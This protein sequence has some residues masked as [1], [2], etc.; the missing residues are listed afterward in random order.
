[1]LTTTTTLLAKNSN[2]R[3]SYIFRRLILIHFFS[4]RTNFEQKF[5]TLRYNC[6]NAKTNFW[7]TDKKENKKN[8]ELTQILSNTQV[9]QFHQS[10]FSVSIHYS[11]HLQALPYHI[12]LVLP[13]EH[14][15]TVPYHPKFLAGNMVPIKSRALLAAHKALF[16]T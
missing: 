1:M 8:K 16:D 10:L 7:S 11:C 14:H 3:L 9:S 13:H 15:F 2:G 5:P 12:R 4:F 6:Y